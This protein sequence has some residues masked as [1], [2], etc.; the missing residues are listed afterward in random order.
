MSPAK[1]KAGNFGS[2]KNVQDNYRRE[3]LQVIFARCLAARSRKF[4]GPG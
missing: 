1:T 4:G 2:G 3:K